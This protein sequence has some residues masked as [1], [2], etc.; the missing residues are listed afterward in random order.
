M[1]TPLAIEF[2]AIMAVSSGV[3]IS[4]FT[5]AVIYIIVLSVIERYIET[6][7]IN[8]GL[9][10]LTGIILVGTLLNGCI[11]YAGRLYMYIINCSQIPF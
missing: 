10:W 8:L 3:I 5:A 9:S 11:L 1:E 6:H 4:L 2:L 7:C